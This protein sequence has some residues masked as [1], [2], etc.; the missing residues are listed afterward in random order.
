MLKERFEVLINLL[1]AEAKSFYGERL[2]SAVLFGSVA[3]GTQN[4]QS[5]VDVLIIAHDLP[6]GR[7]RRIREFEAVE[8]RVEPFLRSLQKEGFYTRISAILKS[9]AEA[10]RGSPL[11]L[12]MVEEGKIL[13]DRG[14][15]FSAVLE[16]LR[17][18]LEA[19]GARRVWKGNAWYWILKP[20]L[21][22]GEVFEL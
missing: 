12:D 19:H 4:F 8:A 21:K 13:F 9:P 10:E 11:F 5:D 20:D 14:G 2:V 1:L 15:F 7:M 17:A 18:R 6:E 3:R 22:P 16:K